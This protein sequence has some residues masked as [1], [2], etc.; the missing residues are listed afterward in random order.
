MG[1]W[2]QGRR[3]AAAAKRELKRRQRIAGPLFA[4][5][6]EPVDVV[7]LAQQRR[8]G[9]AR[10]IEHLHQIMA[11][12]ELEPRIREHYLRRL[13]QES[14]GEWF[15]ILAAYARD[16]YPS[17]TYRATFWVRRLTTTEQVVLGCERIPDPR[18]TLGW[19]AVPSSVFPPEGW[20]PP[21]QAGELDKDEQECKT[22]RYWHSPAA[23][24]VSW[25]VTPE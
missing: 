19:R 8:M 25:E 13:A 9:Q 15:E 1:Q 10:N 11:S 21:F 16:T 18:C 3:D 20:T 22:C 5:Q 2:S 17:A 4:D 23:P 12:V 6:V 24:C 7:A 14:L